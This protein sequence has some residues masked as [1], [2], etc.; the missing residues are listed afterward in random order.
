MARKIRA[1]RLPQ[2]TC[3]FQRAPAASSTD[4]SSS[5]MSLFSAVEM[6]PRDPILGLNEQFAADTN[7]AKVNLGVG[8]YYDDNGKLPLLKCVLA[9]EQQMI[10]APAARGYLPIDGIAAYDKAVQGLVFGADSEIAAR[11]ARGHRA[12]PGRH[13]RP[14][15][16]RRL[17]EEGQPWRQGAD[18][19]PELGEP[20]RAVHQRRLR[21][22]QLPYY[23]APSR[24]VNFEGMLAD[25]KA[26]AEAG[27]VVVLHACCHN[28]TGY[29]ITPAQWDQVVEVVKAAAWSPSSTWPTRALATASPRTAR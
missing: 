29:D 19:R 2:G 28:P 17:P 4:T 14:E 3:G 20:P 13:R 23:D 18:L 27:T 22:R 1:R 15:G 26:A 21:G 12:G 16:G 7:P 25:L 6:A 10:E 8:V 9:A 11:R 24:G 5:S